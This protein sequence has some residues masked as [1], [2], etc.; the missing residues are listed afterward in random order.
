MIVESDDEQR[1]VRGQLTR[2]SD[3]FTVSVNS[4]QRLDRLLSL[5]S[6]GGAQPDLV[7]QTRIDP[8]QDLAWPAGRRL[9]AAT[10]APPEQGWEKHWLDEP[11]P[12]L[13]GLTPRQAA[14]G[15]YRP[16]LE[17]LLREF[18]YDHDLS[19][20]GARHRWL[21]EQLACPAQT[22]TDPP[23]RRDGPRVA[24]SRGRVAMT[25]PAKYP[26]LAIT[27]RDSQPERRRGR[28]RRYGT[29]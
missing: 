4:T 3:T 20:S 28:Y 5:L 15:E 11:V 14:D 29:R 18:E 8:A 6:E 25:Q 16:H 10:L 13:G 1:W 22:R 17:T 7:E 26:L 2:E 12:A 9:T 21:R 24:L 23:R 19:G 27:Q